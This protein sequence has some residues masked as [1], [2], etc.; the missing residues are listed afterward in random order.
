MGCFCLSQGHDRWKISPVSR[1]R[2]SRR[3][4][5]RKSW[6]HTRALAD[7]YLPLSLLI[8][9]ME[10]SESADKVREG[11]KKPTTCFQVPAGRRPQLT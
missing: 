8:L 7:G 6:L 2:G 4:A 5:Q 9:T 1:G 10:R 3:D 11:K